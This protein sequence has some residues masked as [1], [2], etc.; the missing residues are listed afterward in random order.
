[1]LQCDTVT[2]LYL[3]KNLTRNTLV[4]VSDPYDT[5]LRRYERVK[6]SAKNVNFREN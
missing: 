1:M 6:Q 3:V 4:K 2:T 5:Y